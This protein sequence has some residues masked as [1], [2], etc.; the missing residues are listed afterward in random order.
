M[1]LSLHDIA[2]VFVLSFGF[3]VFYFC[4]DILIFYTKVLRRRHGS[5]KKLPRH[6][7]EIAISYLFATIFICGVVGFRLGLPVGWPTIMGLPILILGSHALYT[8][9]SHLADEWDYPYAN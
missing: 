8:M 6:I 7:V 1:D 3:M 5:S 4:K 9:K 2:R